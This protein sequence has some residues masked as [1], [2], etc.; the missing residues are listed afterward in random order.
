MKKKNPKTKKSFSYA[1]LNMSDK[2]LSTIVIYEKR[3]NTSSEKLYVQL[4]CTSTLKDNLLPFFSSHFRVGFFLLFMAV[5]RIMLKR[6]SVFLD[7]R[8]EK[9]SKNKLSYQ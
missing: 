8:G 6:N 4:V 5:K 1:S 9:R 3:I 2:L 7:G